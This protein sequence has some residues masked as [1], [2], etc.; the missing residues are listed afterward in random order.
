MTLFIPDIKVKRPKL[1]LTINRK[2]ATLKPFSCYSCSRYIE[3]HTENRCYTIPGTIFG[4]YTCT[5]LNSPNLIYL[6][7]QV[8]VASYL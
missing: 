5:Q 1:R 3:H 4:S 2:L 7:R 6:Y 8:H